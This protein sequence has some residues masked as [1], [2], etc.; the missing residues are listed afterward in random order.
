[1]DAA[2]KR[3]KA[4]ELKSL[5]EDVS[6]VVLLE[7]SGLTVK[8]A[9]DLRAKFR[10]AGCTYHVYK[11]STIRF[12]VEGT[13]H[14]VIQPLLKGVSGLAFN[15][16]DPGAPARVLRDFAKDHDAVRIKGGAMDGE[17]LDE[18]GIERLAALPGPQ[19]LKAMFL[20]L[21][22]TPATNMVRV[23]N[24]VPQGLLNVLQAKHDQ[25]AA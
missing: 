5:V 9:E 17:L 13:P 25:E 24:A 6:A 7:F 12:G 15:P 3:R 22:M 10:E 11:N 14:E 8:D 4:E 1:M 2:T 20:R 19:E 18:Q 23:M 16:E 21:L